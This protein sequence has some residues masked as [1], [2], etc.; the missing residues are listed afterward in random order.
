MYTSI[1]IYPGDSIASLAER[2]YTDEYG[3]E[4]ALA[5]EI[6]SINH[7]DYDGSLTAGNHIIVPVYR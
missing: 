5:R 2:Y 6:I 1:L 3:D 4:A 7:L